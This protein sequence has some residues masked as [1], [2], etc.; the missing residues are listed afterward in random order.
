MSNLFLK[1]S[2]RERL[3]V[4]ACAVVLGIGVVVYPAH[5]AT[6]AHR[7]GQME[8]L[9]EAQSLLSDYTHLLRSEE[10]VSEENEALID[11]LGNTD[12]LLFD[13]VGNEV[14]TEAMMVK[15]LNQFGPDLGLDISSSRSSL[16]DVPGQFNFNV[17]GGG[18]YPE[19]LNFLYQLEAYRPL[20]VID[21]LNM[22]AQKQKKKRTPPRKRQQKTTPEATE[23][24]MKLAL[25]IH[26]NCRDAEAGDR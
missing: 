15:L 14:M 12:G 18:R 17:K 19:I 24:K 20:I 21:T 11:A 2:R 16:R 3:Y 23:P 9:R 22:G 8:Q 6:A 7:K 26:I 25:T 13:P 1:M 4:I 10:A 5:K